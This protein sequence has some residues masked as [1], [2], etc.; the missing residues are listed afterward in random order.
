MPF[1]GKAQIPKTVKCSCGKRASWAMME[2]AAQIHPSHS[3]MN[4]GRVNPQI[5]KE[6][7]QDYAH[8]NKLLREGGLIEG[9]VEKPDDIAQDYY[10][11]KKRADARPEVEVLRADSIED[12]KALVP[13]D[14]VDWKNTSEKQYER[15][16]IEGA[17]G[18]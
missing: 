9:E 11:R 17:W 14:R 10:D 13:K 7:V 6:I 18:L 8:K 2:R 4:Y 12:L 15:D 3:G 5:G 16:P 1:F